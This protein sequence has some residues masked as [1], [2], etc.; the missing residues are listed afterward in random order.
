MILGYPVS[1]EVKWNEANSLQVGVI[2]QVFTRPTHIQLNGRMAYVDVSDKS[3]TYLI[4]TTGNEQVILSHTDV[5][6]KSVN[7]HT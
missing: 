1:T 3:P 5:I 2:Q 4:L 6:R 7:N